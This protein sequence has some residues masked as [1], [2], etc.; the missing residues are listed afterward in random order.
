MIHFTNTF[1]PEATKAMWYHIDANQLYSH[2]TGGMAQRSS[3]VPSAQ[4]TRVHWFDSPQRQKFFNAMRGPSN[5]RTTQLMTKGRILSLPLLALR[6]LG[7]FLFYQLFWFNTEI[8]MLLT[9]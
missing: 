9:I 3:S 1:S 8:I 7:G 4:L 5:P 2:R 6:R